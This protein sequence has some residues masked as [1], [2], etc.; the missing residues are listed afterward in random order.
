MKSKADDTPASQLKYPG[1]SHD[2]ALALFDRRP[3]RST[4]SAG[5]DQHEDELPAIPIHEVSQPTSSITSPAGCDA[6]QPPRTPENSQ[7]PHDSLVHR[8]GKRR[9]LFAWSDTGDDEPEGPKL[10]LRTARHNELQFALEDSPPPLPK[11]TLPPPSIISLADTASV[12]SVSAPP[13]PSAPLRSATAL[14]DIATNMIDR[15]RPVR[16]YDRSA[17]EPVVLPP[18]QQRMALADIILRAEA[19]A[20]VDERRRVREIEEQRARDKMLAQKTSAVSPVTRPNQVGPRCVSAMYSTDQF[21]R[22]AA[23]M[24]VP[25]RIWHQLSSEERKIARFI[26]QATVAGHGAGE[27]E[28]SI[29]APIDL[30]SWLALGSH[31]RCIRRWSEAESRGCRSVGCDV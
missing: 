13:E 5:S 31:W 2:G 19:R 10:T 6:F 29:L 18:L 8:P 17:S 12:R 25:Q 26:E 3:D 4:G 23:Q 9:K 16:T 28:S 20:K 14:M 24:S 27:H 30:T 15:L 22:G 7:H 21:Y 11:M 1:R